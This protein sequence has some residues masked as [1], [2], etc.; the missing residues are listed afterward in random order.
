MCFRNLRNTTLRK[1]ILRRKQLRQTAQHTGGTSPLREL[2][3]VETLHRQQAGCNRRTCDLW[4][5]EAL[6]D[7]LEH[8]LRGDQLVA[9]VNLAGHP[10]LELHRV[11][12]DVAQAVMSRDVM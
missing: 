11:A 1:N 6:Q 4:G 5:V 3:R 2:D 7:V 9:G 8:H 12:F 10:P